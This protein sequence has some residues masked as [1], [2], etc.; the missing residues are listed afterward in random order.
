MASIHT[1]A[2]VSTDAELASGVSVGAYTIIEAGV[3]I[4][5][6]TEVG[7]HCVIKGD[8]TI[9]ERNRIFQFASIGE[10]PQDKKYA[11][12]PTSLV[13]GD[14]NTIRE[15]C[16]LNRGTAQ[17]KGVTQLGNNNW[18]MAY[19]HIAH[20]CI[21]GNEAIFANNVT[22]AGHVTVGDYAIWGGFSGAHQFARV[23][24]HAFIANNTGVAKDVPPY[25]MAAGL[26]AA[27]RG[28]NSEGL[29]RRGFDADQ[30][31]AIKDAFRLLYRSG[32]R[33]EEAREKI[34]ELAQ[35]R[36]E[37]QILAKFLEHS[38]RGFVR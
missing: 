13:I 11:G 4:G 22:L 36:S 35:E 30:M 2:I 18:L 28:I 14:G 21:I 16:S 17:D 3:T 24:A 5:A 26:P 29:K 25:V 34:A 8:T 31:K 37:I 32:L 7:S 27:P 12:E 19:V 1:T 23:G 33:L 20:D 15:Y 9:G 10:D 6:D 38:E